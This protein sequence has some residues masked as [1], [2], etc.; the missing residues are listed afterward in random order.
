EIVTPEFWSWNAV[1]HLSM[2]GATNVEPSPSRSA[3]S[4]GVDVEGVVPAGVDVEGVDD[5]G[6]ALLAQP[7]R[8]RP[9]TRRSAR[10]AIFMAQ[11]LQ[12]GKERA[13]GKPILDEESGSIRRLRRPPESLP[14]PGVSADRRY[15]L[16]A[17]LGPQPLRPPHQPP[18]SATRHGRRGLPFFPRS[19]VISSLGRR[20][21][22]GADPWGFEPQVSGLGGLRHIR[23]RLRVQVDGLIL[24]ARTP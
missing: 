3:W 15:P 1:R 12:A 4:A 21:K 19:R 13:R 2:R 8:T 18:S 7:A 11:C 5:E 10:E 17:P 24:G 14:P 20:A 9:A 23:A 16:P 6:G 22:R